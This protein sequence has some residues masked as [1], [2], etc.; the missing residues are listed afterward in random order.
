[1]K[2]W[3]GLLFLA[4]GIICP[5][6]DK[7]GVIWCSTP[8]KPGEIVMVFG[9]EWGKSPKVDLG[10]GKIVEPLQ[11]TDSTV[12]FFYPKD[13]PMGIVKCKIVS[14]GQSSREFAL[15]QPDTWWLQGDWGKEASPGGWLRV[16]GRC[17][18]FDNKAAMTL[19]GNG[20][21]IDLKLAGQDCWSLNAA[22]P[23]DLAAGEYEVLLRNGLGSDS[24]PAGKLTIKPH[25]EVWKTKVFN[26]TDYGA[27]ANDG[28]DD[29]VA[30]KT[31]LEA[32]K[33]NGGGI[34]YFP[35]G[36]YQ[37][38][39]M[40]EIPPCTLLKGESMELSQLYWPDTDNP[41]EALIKGTHS[42]GIEELFLTS[43]F[44]Q[45]GIMS[46]GDN[47]TLRRIRT[48]LNYCQYLTS[49]EATRRE[50]ILGNSRILVFNGDFIRVIGC[51]IY[52]V[53]GGSFGISGNYF[54]VTDNI[55]GKGSPVGWS[56]FHGSQMI[57]DNN[58]FTGSQGISF[59]A[60]SA[61][62]TRNI[63]WGNNYQQC[64]FAWDC[65]AFTCDGGVPCYKDTAESI[66][67]TEI[68]LKKFGWRHGV[69]FWKEG[70]VQLVAGKGAGQIRKIAKIDGTKVTVD[71]PWEIQPDEKT[72][73]VIAAF[74]Q[75]F[76][77]VNNET[78]DS[79]VAM[80]LYGSMIS[81]IIADNKTSR[82]GGYHNYGMTK[83][84]SPEV[85]WFVQYFDNRLLEGNAYRGPMNEIPT[86]DAHIAI[87]D[88]GVPKDIGSFPITRACLMRRNILESNARL[89]VIGD[90][91]CSL[92][93]NCVVKNSDIG[94]NIE[95]RAKNVILWGNRFENV[96]KPYQTGSNTLISPVAAV[97]GAISGAT[98]CMGKTAPSEWIK[99]LA[100]LDA[101]AGKNLSAA[102]ARAE[103][104]A[105]LERAVKSLANQ[106][107]DK[108]VSNEVVS[109][110]LGLTL[111]TPN[112]RSTDKIFSDGEAGSAQLLLNSAPSYLP[113]KVEIT[114]GTIPGW[115][116]SAGAM[117]ME[118]DKPG[119]SFISFTKPAGKTG[120]FALPL[121]CTAL[122]KEWKLA[123]DT[124]LKSY[125]ANSRIPIT[126]FLV[127]GPFA[128]KSGKN[129]DSTVHP[130][131]LKLDVTA[132]LE[133][134]D[135]KR[136]WLQTKADK[137]GSLDLSKVFKTTPQSVAYAVAV[138]RAT[139]P[140]QIRLRYTGP[141]M[142]CYLNGTEVGTVQGRGQW[143]CVTLNKG[144]NQLMLVST[145]DG[146][147][148]WKLSANFAV[149]GNI[150]PGD[151]CV[152]PSEELS[153]VPSLKPASGQAVAAGKN[154][155]NSQGVDWKLVFDDNF[156]RRRLGNALEGR[157][158]A[159]WQSSGLK[160]Q[161]N[162]LHVNSFSTIAYTMPVKAPVRIEC[163]VHTNQPSK[164][165]WMGF[166]L[167]PKG[168]S[169]NRRYWGQM[170]GSGYFLS[171]GW[172][173]RFSNGI[174]RNE[175]EVLVDDKGIQLKPNQK[176]HVVAQF[177]PPYCQVYVDGKEVL[178]YKDDNW[179]GGLD[180]VAL[181]SGVP[182]W[183]FDNLLI[184]TG[185]STQK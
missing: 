24:Y 2:K 79:T 6:A 50:A 51:D 46:E 183:L 17:L 41:P 86:L 4:A 85:N 11:V 57:V 158:G 156:N 55:F 179:S 166:M 111:E 61:E 69:N 58:K 88:R 139:K 118:T 181:F 43:G 84:G 123:F 15:N 106:Q 137:S 62:G 136:G 147:P 42:F 37:I 63:F 60:T 39:G 149:F 157:T 40:L 56:G 78:N 145:N 34:L 124:D 117:N 83:G 107:G 142:L 151:L 7:P 168:L 102:E 172:H 127:A 74:R 112:W 110:L 100:E 146:N 116:I 138:L 105:I 19:K 66:N 21:N 94:I 185:D 99:L 120:S 128:N 44:H 64:N 152:I 153:S 160:I 140:I 182:E 76:I 23:F 8:V 48:R 97:S 171:L 122:G 93:E 22:L 133:T 173:D 178:N 148:D 113:C 45:N 150:N 92:I 103:A 134:R 35:R 16:F 132:E 33:A 95:N 27:V 29:T 143:G 77:Y 30:V 38:N 14:D 20:K 13:M 174:M 90:A 96:K 82:S 25:A 144:D 129:I 154:I 75:H 101:L 155:P 26:A 169:S 9:G 12:N 72:F 5:A 119:R 165:Y 176:Y 47:I 67:G 135:G 81:A 131:E 87:R 170:Q 164:T 71:Q 175:K 161:D 80:Q 121:H 73:I 125:D 65:E 36:R 130:P 98:A 163:D 31:A 167:N 89:E 59:G 162:V 91:D 114:A 3:L 10:G 32:I 141:G 104:N 53:A 49:E 52:A 177:V 18:S 115:T 28:F 184:Y 126:D 68:Q 108:P 70:Y 159:S 54:Q 1:M 180:E 109:S